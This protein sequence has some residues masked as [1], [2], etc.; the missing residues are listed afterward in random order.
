MTQGTFGRAQAN[1]VL[2]AI[3]ICALVSLV[4]LLVTIHRCMKPCVAASPVGRPNMSGR[5][6]PW[7]VDAPSPIEI[8][9]RQTV[10]L[11]GHVS[12]LKL[13]PL[14]VQCPE[15][16]SSNFMP[17]AQQVIKSSA[18]NSVASLMFARPVQIAFSVWLFVWKP[19][20]PGRFDSGSRLPCG[21]SCDVGDR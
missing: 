4:Q 6:I 2:V 19:L 20:C 7:Q 11:L 13:L 8:S 17:A 3:F 15:T 10:L 5:L 16:A 9:R 12:I 1:W 14:S 18:A 21:C